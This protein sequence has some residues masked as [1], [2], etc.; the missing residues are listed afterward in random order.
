M[1]E[2]GP[3]YPWRAVVAL[4]LLGAAGVAWAILTCQ[5]LVSFTPLPLGQRLSQPEPPLARQVVLVVADGLRSDTAGRLPI[6][7]RLRRQGAWVPLRA[8]LPSYSWP[9]YTAMLTGAGPT[10]TGVTLNLFP[11]AVSTDTVLLRCAAAGRPCALAGYFP[12]A[13]LFPGQFSRERAHLWNHDPATDLKVTEDALAAMGDGYA[14]VLVH[15]QAV[16]GAGHH[17]GASS[18]RYLEAALLVDRQIG[19]LARAMGPQTALVVASDHGH[20][21]RGGHGG[22][23]EAVLQAFALLYGRGIRPGELPPGT[24]EDLAPTLSVLL[25]V[26]LPRSSLGR[27]LLEGLDLSPS[28]RARLEERSQRLGRE[29]VEDL[30]RSQR[31]APQGSLPPHQEL[32]RGLQEL[33]GRRRGRD[34]PLALALMVASALLLHRAAGPGFRP[35]QALGVGLGLALAWHL[36]YLAVWGSYSVSVVNSPGLGEGLALF[37]AGNAALLA[38]AGC[39]LTRSCLE[40]L[41]GLS[42]AMLGPMLAYGGT[43]GFVLAGQIPDL[44]WGFLFF[45]SAAGLGGVSLAAPLTPLILRSTRVPGGPPP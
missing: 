43:Q 29:L 17:H 42:L 18:P 13:L 21:D 4:L 37:C 38:L 1:E 2:T 11:G 27:P 28:L 32:A 20:R 5:E 41:V 6:L 8:T 35:G 14:L 22:G 26:A 24:L 9:A 12:W 19:R 25:G 33:E 10:F 44:G 30:L 40:P 3:V 16:D 23:E 36:L 31:I 7:G 34:L 39:A 45:L 15:Y